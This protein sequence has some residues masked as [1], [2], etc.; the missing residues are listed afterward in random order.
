VAELAL[1]PE[2]VIMSLC[3]TIRQAWWLPPDPAAMPKQNKAEQ[4]GRLVHRLCNEL[5]RP[6]LERVTSRALRFAERRAAAFD[7]DRCVVVHGDPHPA[8]ALQVL[9]PR[10]GAESGFVLVD[11][12]G[13]L[14][15]PAYDLGVV[16][17]DWCPQ[18]LAAEDPSAQ[19]RHYCHLLAAG[20]GLKETAIWEWGY[21]ER[22]SSGLH[23][24]DLGLDDLARA[25]LTT[26]ESL[27][28]R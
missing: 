19:A 7:P 9:T 4:L 22:V 25:F 20:S 26:A 27:V 6:C 11:P 1:A 13:F 10:A 14:G 18:L 23:C 15:D 21:L 8:N 16:L 3:A 5:G 24:L 28:T 17:R 12:E 2:Q